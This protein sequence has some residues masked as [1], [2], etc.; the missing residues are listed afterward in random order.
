MPGLVAGIALLRAVSRDPADT[1]HPQ[2]AQKV[3]HCQRGGF[4]TLARSLPPARLSHP[5]AALLL[6]GKQH[7][8]PGS[9]E[10]RQQTFPCGKRSLSKLLDWSQDVLRRLLSWVAWGCPLN[11]PP[12]D[13]VTAHAVESVVSLLRVISSHKSPHPVH[14]FESN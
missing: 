14:E 7:I 3:Q 13:L 2:E 4:G 6:A 9:T 10:P 11:L 1:L 8:T 5:A 12:G